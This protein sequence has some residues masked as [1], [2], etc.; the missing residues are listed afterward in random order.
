MAR[1]GEFLDR[2]MTAIR[3]SRAQ[4]R[5]KSAFFAETWHTQVHAEQILADASDQLLHWLV[6]Q[7]QG[8]SL[9]TPFVELRAG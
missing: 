3:G 9:Q 6:A 5:S 4:A 1:L 7:V 2:A 8:S